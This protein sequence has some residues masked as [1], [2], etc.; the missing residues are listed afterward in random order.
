MGL[1]S[2]HIATITVTPWG[3]KWFGSKYDG[4]TVYRG[5]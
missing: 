4:L 1:V 2:N 3:E 5:E